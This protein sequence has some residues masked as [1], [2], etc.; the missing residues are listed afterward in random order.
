MRNRKVLNRM[1]LVLAVV[2]I[3]AM[4]LFSILPF[5]GY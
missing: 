3:A 1:M 2:M 4:I 5:F